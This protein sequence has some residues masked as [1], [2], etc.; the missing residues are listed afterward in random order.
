MKGL[1]RYK[2]GETDQGFAVVDA[3][4]AVIAHAPRW[5]AENV[6]DLLD[7]LDPSAA[8]L[9]VVL[10]ADR[11]HRLYRRLRLA[12]SAQCVRCGGAIVRGEPAWWSPRL[13]LV[14][15]IGRCHKKGATRA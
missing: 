12:R 6:A 2:L 13:R 15:H 9:A 11:G 10:C 5:I 3:D 14:R 8:Q 7:A 4:G 1:R